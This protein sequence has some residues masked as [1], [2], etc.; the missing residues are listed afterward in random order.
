VWGRCV[1]ANVDSAE[2][3]LEAAPSLDRDQAHVLLLHGS[4]DGFLRPGKRLTAPFNDAEILRSGFDYVALGH[5]HEYAAIVDENGR[6]RAAYSGSPAA[7]ARDET[8]ARGA[9]HVRLTIEPGDAAGASRLLASE[10]EPVT[11]DER[12]LHEVTVDL[13]GAGSRETARERTFAA[14]E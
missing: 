12:R 5:Y 14:L 9:I 3:V 10:I 8:G 4:R 2:R 13:T 1:H 11:L 7:L 6:A